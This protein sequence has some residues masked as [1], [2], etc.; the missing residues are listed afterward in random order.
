MLLTAEKLKL[1]I[2]DIEQVI[3]LATQL[4]RRYEFQVKELQARHIKLTCQLRRLQ[5][6]EG[7]NNGKKKIKG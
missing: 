4:Q 1:E 5:K 2:G 6:K 3:T 7:A